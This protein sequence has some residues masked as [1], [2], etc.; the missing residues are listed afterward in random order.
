MRS[1]SLEAT[2]DFYDRFIILKNQIMQSLKEEITQQ[3]DVSLPANLLIK[4]TFEMVTNA[5]KE[6]EANLQKED[7][8]ID[9]DF[10]KMALNAAESDFFSPFLFGGDILDI[11]KRK[12]IT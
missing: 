10:V 1:I 7:F 12:T 9:H 8:F 11:L 4:K 3:K 2:Y 5:F 6:F